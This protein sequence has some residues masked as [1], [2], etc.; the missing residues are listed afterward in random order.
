MRLRLPVFAGLGLTLLIA[1]WTVA[2]RPFVPPDEAFHYLRA[3]GIANGQWL[4]PKVR[5][6]TTSLPPAQLAWVQQS[7][8]GVRVP[9]AL[10]PPGVNCLSGRPDTSTCLEPTTV[11]TYHPLPYLF[12]AVAASVS[13]TANTALWLSRAASALQCLMFIALAVSLLWSGSAW[14]LAGLLAALTPMALF[15]SSV[16]NPNGLEIAAGLA[17]AAGVLR[18]SRDPQPTAPWIWVALAVSGAA[19]IVAW[20]LG[21]VFV[22]ADLLL[23]AGLL[24]RRGLRQLVAGGAGFHWTVAVLLGAAVVWFAYGLISG[25][26]H[27]TFHPS[28]LHAHGGFAELKLA[29]RDAIGNFGTANLPLPGVAR[30]VWWLLVVGLVGVALSVAALRERL[31]MIVVVLLAVAFPIVFYA[32]VYRFSGYGL[33]GRYVLPVLMLIPLLAGELISRRADRLIRVWP[34]MLL[35]GAL[36][37]IALF[38]AYTWWY[39]AS[40]AAGR[41][42]QLGFFQHASWHPPLGW[43]PWIGI[44]LFGAVLLLGVAL[45]GAL[46]VAGPRREER[47]TGPAEGRP[48]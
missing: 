40:H 5:L 8:R 25:V 27:L 12:P 11:G 33:Q 30:W 4:G 26:D 47:D 44:A 37:V 23:L 41:P 1:S 7:T 9:A 29:L 38:Q 28:L 15:V 24:R 21:P 16:V 32:W 39:A 48:W 36:G 3:V 34:R 2:T 20:Q 13:H 35:G 22:V 43:G 14:S 6:S 18:L 46:N 31:L 10:A 17:F 42:T 19:T 45:A